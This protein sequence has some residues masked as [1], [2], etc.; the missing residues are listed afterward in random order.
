MKVVAWLEVSVSGA[1]SRAENQPVNL[2]SY[3]LTSE[4]ATSTGV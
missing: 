1:V 2:Y 4:A 3:A